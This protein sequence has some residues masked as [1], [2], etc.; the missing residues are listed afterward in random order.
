[1]TKFLLKIITYVKWHVYVYMYK[2][3]KVRPYL[4]VFRGELQL[5]MFLPTFKRIRNKYKSQNQ[6]F[7]IS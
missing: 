6:A 7:S 3:I 5:S 2:Y 4:F 1:M